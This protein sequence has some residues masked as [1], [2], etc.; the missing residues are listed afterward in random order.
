MVLRPPLDADRIDLDG[1]ACWM[2]GSGPPLLLVHSV[3]AAASAAEVRPVFDA[4]RDR[5]TVMAPDL[6]GFGTSRRENVDYT[7]RLMTDAVL[8]AVGELRRRCGTQCTAALAVSLGCEFVARAAV[9]QPASLSRLALVSPTGMNGTRALRGRPGTTRQ[10]P[11]LHPLLSVP[12]WSQGLFSAL[13]RPSVVRYFLERTWGAR[14]IDEVMWAYAVQTARE[15]GARHAPLAFLAGRLFSADIT[16]VYEALAQPVWMSHGTRGDFVDYRG[17]ARF[18]GSANWRF[19]VYEAGALP[20]FEH[21][22]RFA[23]DLQAFLDAPDGPVAP[24]AP[25]APEVPTAGLNPA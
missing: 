11:G 18:E 2:A 22:A 9:E 3:N 6:P 4:M 21:A 14:N 13:T 12:L 7:P 20:Y 5:F 24:E 8:R 1:M 10:V 17:K 23:V 15:G 19:T 16:A 25:N